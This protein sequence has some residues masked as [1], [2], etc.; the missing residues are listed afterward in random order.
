MIVCFQ[1][2]AFLVNEHF[3]PEW[4]KNV[5]DITHEVI[6]SMSEANKNT[7]DSSACYLF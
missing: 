1:L 7:D 5:R 4:Q 6:V 2:I 3:T